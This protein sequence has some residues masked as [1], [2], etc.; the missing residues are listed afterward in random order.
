M[1]V[2]WEW[3]IQEVPHDLRRQ[4]FVWLLTA[5]TPTR[6]NLKTQQCFHKRIASAIDCEQDA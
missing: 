3:V 5:A 1:T 6:K 4:E 2:E